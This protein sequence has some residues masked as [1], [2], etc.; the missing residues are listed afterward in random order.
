MTMEMAI[1]DFGAGYRVFGPVELVAGGRFIGT[2]LEATVGS[3]D[4]DAGQDLWN[5]FIGARVRQLFAERWGV[6]VHGD[7]GFGE[8]ESN[9]MLQAVGQFRVLDWLGIDLGYKWLHNKVEDDDSVLHS[10]DLDLHG[11][12]VGVSF[13]F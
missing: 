6:L 4:P 11:A 10:A 12:V 13:V 8:S 5:G 7:V 2:D 1:V 3:R 9:Y